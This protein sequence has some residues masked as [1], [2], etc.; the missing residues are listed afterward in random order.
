M[1]Y[2]FQTEPSHPDAD[3]FLAIAPHGWAA[4]S[5]AAAAITRA[6]IEGKPGPVDLYEISDDANPSITI[7]G[8]YTDDDAHCKKVATLEPDD[9]E[10]FAAVIKAASEFIESLLSTADAADP[11]EF[12][13]F[14]H[15]AY[16]ADDLRHCFDDL[17][18]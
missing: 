18:R 13:N 6:I 17:R 4:A 5:T 1:I 10:Q 8:L 9:P 2:G 3:R 11:E 14:E 16:Y 12:G 7:H 15:A